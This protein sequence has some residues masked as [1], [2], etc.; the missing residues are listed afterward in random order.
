MDSH[1]LF[2]GLVHVLGLCWPRGTYWCEWPARHPENIVRI[3]SWLWPWAMSGSMAL[4]RLGVYWWPWPELLSKT[5]WLS[6]V[7]AAA[8]SLVHVCGQIRD[9]GAH[10]CGWPVLPP[11]SMGDV[12]PILPQ[13][14]MRGSVV[15]FWPGLCVDVHVL[16]YHS[17]PCR[18]SWE[19]L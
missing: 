15:L 14:A 7:C 8:W 19:V 5:M 6:A 4:M 3:W 18:Y 11:A 12:W 2:Y 17:E 10:P 13:R 1:V 16:C 9:G